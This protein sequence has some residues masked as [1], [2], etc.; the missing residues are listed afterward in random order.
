MDLLKVN[1]F[2]EKPVPFDLLV[3]SIQEALFDTHKKSSLLGKY[4]DGINPLTKVLILDDDITSNS[5]TKRFLD[6][7]QLTIIQAYTI[8]DVLYIYIYILFYREWINLEK[9]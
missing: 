4:F 1:G 7:L 3:N 5:I 8:K 9:L 6:S 2:I